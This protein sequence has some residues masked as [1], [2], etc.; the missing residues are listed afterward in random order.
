LGNTAVL[1]YVC[2]QMI[3]ALWCCRLS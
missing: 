2:I 3:I 1:L